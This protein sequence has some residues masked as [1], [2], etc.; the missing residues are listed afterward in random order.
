MLDNPLKSLSLLL[1]FC[2]LSMLADTPMVS[3]EPTVL[4]HVHMERLAP[5]NIKKIGQTS[6]G[7]QSLADPRLSRVFTN[8][9]SNSTCVANIASVYP[10]PRVVKWIKSKAPLKY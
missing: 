6:A 9:L 10:I 2:S 7:G 8:I 1:V 3:A 5:M 4:P